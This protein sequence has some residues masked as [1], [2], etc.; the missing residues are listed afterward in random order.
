MKKEI[1]RRGRK[2]APSGTSPSRDFSSGQ[3][4]KE[5]GAKPSVR[6]EIKEIK[7]RAGTEESAETKQT[8]S[9]DERAKI[10]EKGKREVMLYGFN[11][12][13]SESCGGSELGAK[14]LSKEEYAALKK[15]ERKKRGCRSMDRHSRCSRME[16]PCRSFWIL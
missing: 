4:N 10:Q 1:L 6:A 13:D 7:K 15:Q 14:K 9:K 2:K 8:A 5:H 16:R 11:R 3:K 12:Y